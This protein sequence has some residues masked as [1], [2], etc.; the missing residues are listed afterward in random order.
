MPNPKDIV[1]LRHM[2]DATRKAIQF[3]QG[4]SRADLDADDMLAL[5]LVRL[6]EGVGEA[7]KGVSPGLRRSCPEIPWD[8]IGGT[9]DR[10]IHGYFDVDFDI[11]W[12][13]I[14]TDLPPLIA[15]LEKIVASENC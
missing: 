7:S 6:L 8:P 2:L 13:I 9:R 12:A 4:Q 3:V 10:L 15:Q 14:T 11:V 1:R 5:A